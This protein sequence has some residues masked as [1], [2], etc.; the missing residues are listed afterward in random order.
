MIRMP[1]VSDEVLHLQ[2]TLQ[3]V[4][5]LIIMSFAL[6]ILRYTLNSKEINIGL[7]LI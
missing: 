7:K 4:K 1:V 2:S 6:E 5:L 3:T